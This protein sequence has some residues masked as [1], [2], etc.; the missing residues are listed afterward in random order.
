[1]SI[2]S[3]LDG[4]VF[5]ERRDGTAPTVLAMHGWGRDRHDMT[6]VAGER[7]ALVPDLPGFGASP[8]PAEACGSETY[9]RTIAALL[10]ADGA[11]PYVVVGHSFGGRI[12]TVLAAERPE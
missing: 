12:A 10:E 7:A 2:R 5:A 4:S 9:A 3:Y 8:A 11:A 1:M 6:G